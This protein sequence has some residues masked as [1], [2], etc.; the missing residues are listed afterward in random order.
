MNELQ[1]KASAAD[2]PWLTSDRRVPVADTSMLNHSAG[3]RAGAD[4]RRVGDGTAAAPEAQPAETAGPGEAP[5][6][7]AEGLRS[8]VRSHPLACLAAAL[9]AGLLIARVTR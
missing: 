5:Q 3:A 9:A 8:T 7:W 6:A 4:A 2:V 1:P